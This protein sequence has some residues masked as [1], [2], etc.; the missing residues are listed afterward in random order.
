MNIIF[1]WGSPRSGKTS[2]W[3]FFK[4]RGY[5]HIECDLFKYFLKDV[6]KDSQSINNL[7]FYNSWTIWDVESSA[8]DIFNHY[9]NTAELMKNGFSSVFE[10]INMEWNTLIESTYLLPKDL[11]E[12]KNKYPDVTVFCTWIEEYS[13]AKKCIIKWLNDNPKDWIHSIWKNHIEKIIEVIVLFSQYVKK[14]CIKY[15]IDYIS[16]E[17]PRNIWLQKIYNR[18]WK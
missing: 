6:I 9:L 2:L 10:K 1:I 3:I 16:Y 13:L 12:I 5:Q 14:E 17:I 7:W 8:E 4:E 15:D 11:F 18:N